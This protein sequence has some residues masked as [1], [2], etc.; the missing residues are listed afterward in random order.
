MREQRLL[1]RIAAC[2]RA[3]ERSH[4]TRAD[5]LMRSILDHLARI[6]NTRQGS[7]PCAPDFG[8]PD[9]T[10][11]AGSLETGNLDQVIDEVRRLV[12]RYEPRLKEPRLTFLAGDGPKLTLSFAIEGRISIDQHDV[13][14]KV[15]SQVSP[16]GR[17]LLRR[18]DH[19]EHVL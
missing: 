18:M 5:L 15:I 11:L 14:M 13:R 7:V 9:F 3:E 19:A 16:E 10:N 4:S 12:R 1:E 8:V 2:E 17:V 6:L